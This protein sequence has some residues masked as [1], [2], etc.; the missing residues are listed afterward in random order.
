M[1]SRF[2]MTT[3]WFKAR[4]T[5]LDSSTRKY[6]VDLTIGQV[7]HRCTI[8]WIPRVYHGT[9]SIWVFYPVV[10]R[11]NDFYVW[12]PINCLLSLKRLNWVSFCIYESQIINIITG[13]TVDVHSYYTVAVKSSIVTKSAGVLCVGGGESCHKIVGW[14]KG[15][16]HSVSFH[17]VK[18]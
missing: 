5:G 18:S 14:L 3:K 17:I 7:W 4:D 16:L 12:V 8:S 9:C 1:T 2:M 13:N 11:N 15:L 10:Y 6:W